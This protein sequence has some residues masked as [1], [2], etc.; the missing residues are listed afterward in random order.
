MEL[1]FTGQFPPMK[2]GIGNLMFMRCLSPPGDGLRV[3]A[4]DVEGCQDWD[5]GS[6]IRI[7][8]FSYYH[9][10]SLWLRARQVWWAYSALDR[11]LRQQRYRLITT[12]LF[13]PFGLVAGL[14]KRKY[15]HKVAT[16]CHGAELL[17]SM[18]FPPARLVYKNTMPRID[19]Y[20]ANSLMTANL[21]VSH[22]WD[23]SHIRLIPPPIDT[24]RFHPGIG[25][26]KFREAWTKGKSNNPIM[27]TVTRLDD[28]GK[29]VDTVIKLIPEL[30]NRFPKIQ[31]VIVG[32]GSLR[33][34]YEHLAKNLGVQ[35]N[36]NFVGQVSDDDLPHCY[37]ACDLFILL[38]R[39]ER[40][41]G[42]CEGYGMVYR[43]AMACGKPVIVSKEAGIRDYIVHGE[44]ALLADPRN[45]T[46]ILQAC[47]EILNN[48]TLATRLGQQGSHYALQA[49]DWSPLDKFS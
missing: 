39:I 17:R 18:L 44:T 21:L 15:G 26:G 36:I 49:P 9:G 20:I 28:R 32:D 45:Q 40:E 29:G 24:K 41:V 30:R 19:L 5:K 43:E 3:L 25:C 14:L 10:G 22:G 37:A 23:F 13:F 4:A 33:S 6:G 48:P 1:V 31:Y 47:F 42:Y 27:L 34:E 46:E 12:D 35:E 38:S 8:R 2:G 11:E 16:F 7:K